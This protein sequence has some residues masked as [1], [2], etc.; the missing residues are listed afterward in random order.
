LWSNIVPFEFVQ[1]FISC[2]NAKFCYAILEAL[3]Y[4]AIDGALAYNLRQNHHSGYQNIS[5]EDTDYRNREMDQNP[6][7]LLRQL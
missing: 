6:E 1:L 3:I 2:F 5:G 4:L 7:I